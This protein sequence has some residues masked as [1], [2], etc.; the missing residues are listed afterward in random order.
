MTTRKHA[1]KFSEAEQ[2]LGIAIEV[3]VHVDAHKDLSPPQITDANFSGAPSVH[4]NS[5]FHRA[6][7]H[8]AKLATPS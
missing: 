6:N 1:L 8:P 3:R 4:I 7:A 2:R 5:T